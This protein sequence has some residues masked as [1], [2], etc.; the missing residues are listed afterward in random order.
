[1]TL[2][3]LLPWVLSA[4]SI[5]KSYWMG[6]KNKWG[7]RLGVVAQILWFAYV[8]STQEWGLLPGVIG[9]TIMKVRTLI[10]W[11]QDIS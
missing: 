4:I 8:F 6:D 1:M 2:L 11:E 5:V 9:F 3:E 7:P 10:L